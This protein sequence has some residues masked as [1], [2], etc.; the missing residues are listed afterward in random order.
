MKFEMFL[1]V[2]FLVQYDWNLENSA[3]KFKE[4][5]KFVLKRYLCKLMSSIIV[6]FHFNLAD[7]SSLRSHLRERRDACESK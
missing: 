3:R 1:L 5:K 4:M 6:S 7:L 2:N